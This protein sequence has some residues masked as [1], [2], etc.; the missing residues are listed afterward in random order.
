MEEKEMKTRI[1]P[2][3]FLENFQIL[4]QAQKERKVFKTIQ[5]FLDLNIDQDFLD[6]AM[7][8]KFIS[9]WTKGDCYFV[10]MNGSNCQYYNSTNLYDL[11]ES[12]GFFEF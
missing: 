6:W 12:L 4:K 3:T 10:N 11:F 9:F 8:N 5:D 7:A 1:S 2:K